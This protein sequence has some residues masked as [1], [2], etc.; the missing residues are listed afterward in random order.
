MATKE[1]LIL[2][3][4]RLA[5]N[6]E[7]V[8]ALKLIQRSPETAAVASKLV[9]S[10]TRSY[11]YNKEGNRRIDNPDILRMREQAVR[12]GRNASDSEMVM[13]MLPEMELC[14]QILIS[15]ILSPKD[16]MEPK[17]NLVAPEGVLPSQPTS[18]ILSLLRAHFD[19]VY[20][21]KNDLPAILRDAL[22]ETG[23]H[24]RAVIPESSIDELINRSTSAG[25]ESVHE[26]ITASQEL[27]NFGLLGKPA[28][29]R[30]N[31]LGT[32][33][34]E[35]IDVASSS[36]NIP[37]KDDLFLNI[38]GQYLQLHSDAQS[39]DK[40]PKIDFEIKDTNTIVTD[41]PFVL[42]IP[43]LQEV[44][45]E[46]H[47]EEVLYRYSNNRV[48]MESY[49]VKDDDTK[50]LSDR[51]L[52]SLL[53]RPG[54]TKHVV[55]ATVKTPEQ[56]K[57][58]TVGAPMILQLPSES[59][60]PV[61]V[62][63]QE[64]AHVGYFVLLDSNGN[65]ISRKNQRDY[66]SEFSQR[67]SG[68]GGST[69]VQSSF[70]SQVIQRV[71][72]LINGFD[73]GNKE[74]LDYSFRVYQDMVEQD[75]LAR[76][77]NGVYSNGVSLANN[78]EIYRIMFSRTL[79]GQQSQVLFLPVKL[80][81]YFAFRYSADGIG[82]SL[83]DDMKILNSLRVMVMFANTMASIRN[84]IPTQIINIKMDEDDP[85]P[86]KTAERQM[87]EFVRVKQQAFPI[88]VS[89]PVDVTDFLQRSG[90]EFKF[91]GH[92]GLPDIEIERTDSQRQVA[93][94]DSEF[95]EN[96][97]K[98]AIMATGLNP[99]TV[100][101]GFS[102]EFATSVVANNIL[103][104]R[105][106]FQLQ[107]TF[108]PQLADH[109]RKVILSTSDLLDEMRK[110]ISSSVD[111]KTMSPDDLLRVFGTKEYDKNI[112]TEYLLREFI[113]GLGV[114]L[115]NP[116]ATTFENQFKAFESFIELLDQALKAWISS[117]F[118][119]AEIAGQMA[120]PVEN[121][122]QMIRA[123]FVRRFLSENGILPELSSITAEGDADGKPAIDLW[124]T[125]EEH[126]KALLRSFS[127]FFKGMQ[128]PK[129]AADDIYASVQGN[130]GGGDDFGSTNA[131]I[132]SSTPASDDFGLGGDFDAE[133][134]SQATPEAPAQTQPETPS[135]EETES[136]GDTSEAGAGKQKESKEKGE[137]NL[138]GDFPE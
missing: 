112:V 100:D 4:V 96:L 88:A 58:R 63:G 91:S 125:N 38:K 108:C 37:S 20:R 1:N 15:S 35:S 119:T 30:Q 50:K 84:S 93:K 85:D 49:G 74:H 10:K 111:E 22:F 29:T 64:N 78:E 90:Y 2:T 121:I 55:V 82:K 98:R 12:V 24:I 110:I 53:Y 72:T 26:L 118:F 34:L 16:M 67:L 138:N 113:Y 42:K 97:R 117:D 57:R 106:V 114:S 70:S 129:Q 69:S 66:Y 41:N 101:N 73:C 33:S 40:V 6:G 136:T 89:S 39:I 21:I 54:N 44:V 7:S 13:Q 133:P 17:L 60:I 92:P 128:E 27:K 126:V 47:I 31:S 132:D 68:A 81:S 62:P 86:Y 28:Q 95:E 48:S 5:Q 122:V 83:L 3:S 36:Q 18:E 76:L 134:S 131:Q 102:G 103:L 65:P 109:L 59:V 107:T 52:A 11:S 116:N 87:T 124:E 127:K 130:A 120:T 77:K 61:H 137:P 75:L 99:E 23:S 104:A 51:Q 19:Q 32:I 45:R 105:R 8:P 25:L 94:P 43:V 14:A 135:D 80:V 115:P 46:R 9:E 79:A 123:Y 56:L 71:N